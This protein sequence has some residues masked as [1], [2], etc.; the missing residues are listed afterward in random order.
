MTMDDPGQEYDARRRATDTVA[1]ML[2]YDFDP[3]RLDS[4][5]RSIYDN[6][7]RRSETNAEMVRLM[8]GSARMT[9]KAGRLAGRTEDEIRHDLLG[10]AHDVADHNSVPGR[11]GPDEPPR[12]DFLAMMKGIFELASAYPDDEDWN[13]R[14][15]ELERSLERETGH[16]RGE[17]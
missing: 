14:V 15:E 5:S 1:E 17:S 10:S 8:F 7:V 12:V 2:S 9:T 6:W 3:D 13:E 11:T 4:R 16:D